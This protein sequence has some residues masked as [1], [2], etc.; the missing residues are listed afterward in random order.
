MGKPTASVIFHAQGGNR[1]NFRTFFFGV[2]ARLVSITFFDSVHTHTH[3]RIEKFLSLFQ[4]MEIVG[5][6]TTLSKS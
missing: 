4:L 5:E 6:V 1:G 3:V 2:T